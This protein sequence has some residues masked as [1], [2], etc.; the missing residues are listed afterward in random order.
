MTKATPP[1]GDI[2]LCA[3]VVAREA[4]SQAKTARS[5]LRAF[6]RAR[7]AALAGHDHEEQDEAEAMEAREIAILKK[8]GFPNPY[9]STTA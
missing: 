2:A 3:P 4:R 7:P 6:A 8:L 9:L 1:T 5:A